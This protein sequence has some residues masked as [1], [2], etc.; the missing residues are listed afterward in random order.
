MQNDL[1]EIKDLNLLGAK[2]IS[3]QVFRDGRGF[4]LESHEIVRY[5]E[6]GIEASFVQD[7]HSYSKQGVIRECTFNLSR[8]KP[9][10]FELLQEKFM[11]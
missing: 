6:S 1:M 8:G 4:F 9:S 2:L 3:P 10:L 5:R 11:M 7:N